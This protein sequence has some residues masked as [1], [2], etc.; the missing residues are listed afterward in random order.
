MSVGFEPTPGAPFNRILSL[1]TFPLPTPGPCANPY[2]SQPVESNCSYHLL[3]QN[4]CPRSGSNEHLRGFNSALRP[5]QLLG[6]KTFN[7]RTFVRESNPCPSPQA[8][9]LAI[10]RTKQEISNNPVIKSVLLFSWTITA[11]MISLS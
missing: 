7:S 6:Q 5:H 2:T 8:G 9:V 1:Q 4:W 10:R 11:K 3:S